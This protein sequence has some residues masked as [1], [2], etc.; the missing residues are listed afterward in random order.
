MNVDVPTPPGGVKP[1]MQ[2]SGFRHIHLV[3]LFLA[4]RAKVNAG[5]NFNFTALHFAGG[6]CGTPDVLARLLEAGADSLARANDPEGP[7]HGCLPLDVARAKIPALLATDA[8]R[9]L[10][11]LSYEG[12]G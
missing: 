6:S 3:D 5:S 10:E 1:L 8:G 12:T 4:E 7:D 11:R 9:W 2:T